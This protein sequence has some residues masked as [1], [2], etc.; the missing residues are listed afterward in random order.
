MRTII[1]PELEPAREPLGC[2]GSRFLGDV[3]VELHIFR[4]PGAAVVDRWDR[5]RERVGVVGD[6]GGGGGRSSMVSKFRSEIS[7]TA[8]CTAFPSG[9]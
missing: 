7:P 4:D 9:S 8:A 3:V 1:R 2:L 5:D 6:A